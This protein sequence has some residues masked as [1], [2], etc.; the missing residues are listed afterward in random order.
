MHIFS[1]IS[2]LNIFVS[3]LIDEMNACVHLST[4][5]LSF[6]TPKMTCT[7]MQRLDHCESYHVQESMGI[8]RAR[9]RHDGLPLLKE[10]RHGDASDTTQ[11]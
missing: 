6:K 1:L 10:H 3:N 11:R 7:L 9:A 8:L 5:E 4:Q 2:H